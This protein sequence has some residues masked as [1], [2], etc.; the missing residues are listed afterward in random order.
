MC[1][2]ES[3]R[4]PKRFSG[5]LRFRQQSAFPYFSRVMFTWRVLVAAE[6]SDAALVS[7][8]A[9]A[10][11]ANDINLERRNIKI[12][13]GILSFLDVNIIVKKKYKIL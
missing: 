12:T 1:D 4:S 2:G 5:R 6:R 13:L 11:V 3:G 9:H 7:R 8:Q 10:T